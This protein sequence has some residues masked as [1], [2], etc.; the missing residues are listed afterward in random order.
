[1]DDVLITGITPEQHNHR[2][3]E[4]F[5]RIHGKGLRASK[6]KSIL[7]VMEVE[8]LGHQ[9]NGI[10]VKPLQKNLKNIL[11][12]KQPNNKA[13][14]QSF[15]GMVNYY[16]RFIEDFAKVAAPLYELLKKGFHFDWKMEQ[17]E[18]FEILKGKIGEEPIL[19]CFNN[20][21]EII[22]SVDA[23]NKGVGG[24]LLHII[25]G[26]ERPIIFFPEFLGMSKRDIR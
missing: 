4:V 23:S 24:A 2:L 6:E 25:D 20:D 8:Y 10:E 7:G 19:V 26:V 18:A 17:Q 9:I 5:K 14:V 13:E 16:H 1:M 22:L 15:L 3:E 21:L 12:L 11:N